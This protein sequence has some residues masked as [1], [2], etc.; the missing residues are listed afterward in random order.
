MGKQVL[1]RI[2]PFFLPLIVCSGLGQHLSLRGKNPSPCVL[3]N[4]DLLSAV[5]AV[6]DQLLLVSGRI[7]GNVPCHPYKKECKYPGNDRDFP[8]FL[9][10]I[11]FTGLRLQF[12]LLP[13]LPK[14]HPCRSGVHILRLPVSF[15]CGGPA[16]FAAVLLPALS[17]TSP[18]PR[19]T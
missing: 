14:P 3:G 4:Q 17:C 9:F 7:I 5:I 6:V 16:L 10:N 12:P 18:P 2:F 19:Q 15:S 13:I 8:V 11:L 1:I